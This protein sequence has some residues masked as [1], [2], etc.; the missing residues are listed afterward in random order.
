MCT[1]DEKMTISRDLPSQILVGI[2]L[3]GDIGVETPDCWSFGP[4]RRPYSH[5]LGSK[6]A[7][8]VSDDVDLDSPTKGRGSNRTGDR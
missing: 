2:A 8:N 1:M 4:I 3:I 5:A 6:E 7:P